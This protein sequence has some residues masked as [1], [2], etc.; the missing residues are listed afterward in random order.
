[1]QLE[2]ALRG[3]SSLLRS[4]AR[5]TNSHA[6][7]SSRLSSGNHRQPV[8]YSLL[9]HTKS[10]V[11]GDVRLFSTS[12]RAFNVA[13]E[14]SEALKHEIDAEKDLEAQHPAASPTMFP[15]FAVTTKE[16][17]VRLTKTHG[18]ESILV[19]FNVNHSVEIAEEFEDPNNTPAPVAL[20]PF[21]IEITKGDERLCFQ[22]E[23]VEAEQ[24]GEYD[25]QVEEFYIAPAVKGADE[26]VP[27]HVYATSGKYI[28]ST[29]QELLYVRYLEER[30][31]DGEFLK[32]LVA[33][34]SS[35]EHKLYINLLNKMKAFIAK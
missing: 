24:P 9:N 17:E 25:F 15:G 18:N 5:L 32:N 28:D 35:H 31:F 3:G 26:D 23:L 27:S 14:L 33:F 12:P 10:V 21:S 1:S 29:I 6:A 2:M 19:V 20:P 7:V 8:D 30:G 16:A 22:L 11:L 4:L 34:A 13:T